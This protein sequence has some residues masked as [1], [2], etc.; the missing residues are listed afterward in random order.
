MN[1]DKFIKQ[2]DK[3]L[4]LIADIEKLLNP[5]EMKISAMPIILK[6]TS[7]IRLIKT[8]FA[9]EDATLYEKDKKE[10][11]EAIE[12]KMDDLATGIR[13]FTLKWKNSSDIEANPNTFI[14]ES[15]AFFTVLKERIYSEN[16]AFSVM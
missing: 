7:L 10:R 14:S 15:V 6:L 9:E 1:S 12:I 5:S 2:H 3:I 4:S 8:H 13:W 11:E 16:K